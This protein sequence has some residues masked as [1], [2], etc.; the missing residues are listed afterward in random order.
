[1]K[2]ANLKAE[3]IPIVLLRALN[4]GNGQFR[5]QLANRG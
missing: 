3:C 1:M 5:H 2:P 4:I